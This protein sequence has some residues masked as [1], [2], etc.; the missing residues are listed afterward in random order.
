MDLRPLLRAVNPYLGIVAVLVLLAA[1]LGTMYL[2]WFELQWLAFL[3]GMLMAA[4][5]AMV[6]RASRTERSNERRGQEIAIL[7]HQLTQE[8]ELRAHAEQALDAAR[9]ALKH[10]DTELPVMLAYVDSEQRV[11]YHNQAFREWGQASGQ[12]LGRHLREV[13]GPA[14]Y[15]D[16]EAS[17][18]EALSGRLVRFERT[19]RTGD[20][21]L[22]RV[23]MQYV[24]RFSDGSVCGF[25]ALLTD[26]TSRSD[27]LAAETPAAEAAAG[28]QKTYTESL[29][30]QVTGR[31][32]MP[33][34]L[35]AALDT[36]EFCLYAQT[37][38]PVTPIAGAKAFHEILIRL[39][40][41]ER[42]LM[43]PG[44]F[45]PMAEEQGLLPALDRWVVNHLLNWVSGHPD[46]QEALYSI[47]ISGATLGDVDFAAFV[48][49]SLRSHGLREG[50]LC[51]EFTES[52]AAARESDGKATRRTLRW[53]GRG[54]SRRKILV[55][56]ASVPSLPIRSWVSWYPVAFFRTRAPVRR[57]SPVGRTDSRPRT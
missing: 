43:P 10:C 30:R 25:Y 4:V 32:D 17:I 28:E 12:I 31:D 23:A 16:M 3:G 35:I 9:A 5:L 13:L 26:I 41:E 56:R 6:A 49:E 46:R 15:A 52:D 20:R 36:N 8:T 27:A 40:E 34:R 42:S 33:E 48:R 50:L 18:E 45:L 37:I 2:T 44:A 19:R 54:I 53:R 47:N 57:T 24:P 1:L 11:Q 29:A 7:R 22:F 55:I 51:I 38:V 21:P 14:D 39:K